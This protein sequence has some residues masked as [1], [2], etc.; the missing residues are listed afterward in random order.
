VESVH[1]IAEIVTERDIEI[2]LITVPAS[3]AQDIVEQLASAGVTSILNFAPTV[4]HAPEG[5]TIR[6]VDIA[7]TLGVLAFHQAE[8]ERK[9]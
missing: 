7:V 3:A 1:D 4:I 2:G 5:V 9:S 8:E 6:R